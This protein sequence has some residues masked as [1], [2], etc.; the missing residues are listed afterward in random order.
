MM[1]IKRRKDLMCF[2]V[3]NF[4]EAAIIPPQTILRKTPMGAR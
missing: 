3:S 2:S 1:S 4:V